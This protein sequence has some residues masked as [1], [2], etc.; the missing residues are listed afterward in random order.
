MLFQK[1][2]FDYHILTT[3]STVIR[4]SFSLPL[5]FCESTESFFKLQFMNFAFPVTRKIQSF[6]WCVYPFQKDE[7][8]IIRERSKEVW[9]KEN[10]L[11]P[12]ESFI[13]GP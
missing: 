13:G 8:S 1:K 3:N 6:D 5:H 4:R 9:C 2:E 12:P 10:G 7:F 11:H